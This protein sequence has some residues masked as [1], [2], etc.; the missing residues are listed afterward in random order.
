MRDGLADHGAKAER[1]HLAKQVGET[2][3]GR[4]GR[5]LLSRNN[6]LRGRGF[7]MLQQ[8]SNEFLRLVKHN[9]MAA[10]HR[11]R[12]P[13]LCLRLV[14]ERRKW[15]VLSVT[16]HQN[17]SDVLDLV[18]FTGQL[19]RLLEAS[20]WL[21]RTLPTHPLSISSILNVEYFWR[22][23]WNLPAIA[24]AL[25]SFREVLPADC[26]HVLGDVFTVVEHEGIQIDERA[27]AI[28]NAIGNAADYGPTIGMTAQHDVG[29][30]LPS[31]QVDDIKNMR[32]EVDVTAQDLGTLPQTSERWCKNVVASG[33]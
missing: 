3:V 27:N 7:A 14:A 18:D 32:L 25:R 17:E 4:S 24:D 21:H 31:D 20:N 13:A 8:D 22:N 9:H 15:R 33:L 6:E 5:R 16:S 29:E 30:F 23:R 2:R 10:R 28:G 19:D 12:P 11:Q 1:S 26:R